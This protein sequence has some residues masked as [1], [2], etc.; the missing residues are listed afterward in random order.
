MA[1]TPFGSEGA[2][3]HLF[4]ILVHGVRGRPAFPGHDGCG[5]AKRCGTRM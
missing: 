4:Q 5:H 1:A 3:G 2:P